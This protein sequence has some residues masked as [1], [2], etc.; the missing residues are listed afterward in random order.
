MSNIKA[1]FPLFKKNKNLVYLDN[2]ATTQ[3]PYAMLDALTQYY[4][5][6]NSNVGRGVYELAQLSENAYDTSKKLVADFIGCS[7]TNLVYTNGCTESLNLAGYISQQKFNKTK[8]YIVLPISEHHANVLIWQEIALKN[9]LELYWI[10][11]PELILDP[12]KINSQILNN[13][14]IMT[15]AHVSNVT[16]E[17]Y[18][19]EIWCK[20]AKDFGA[21]S[22]IDGAQA[23]TSLKINI[24]NI[25]CDFYAFSAHKIYGPMGLGV[26][27]IK[28]KYISANPYKL[29]G[30]IIEDV[31]KS[32]YTLL[33]EINKFEAGTPNVANAYAFGK[34]IEFLTENNWEKLLEKTHE[35]GVYLESELVKI[36]INPLSVSNKF[37]KTHISSFRIPGIHAHDVGT[38]LAKKNIAVRV[39]KHCTYPLHAHLKV[40]SSVRASIGIYN[41]KED[42]DVLIN[43]IKE[44][45]NYFNK[46]IK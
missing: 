15:V 14:A 7:S 1:E 6:F 27:Y 38:Y 43:A 9:N 40:N 42:V 31:E 22:I 41:N 45:I 35:I 10:E 28:D 18:P 19:V 5:E 12:Y 4:I 23:V 46:D 3:K 26:L 17:V 8:K 32:S 33:D 34:T 21:I 39:G 36:G 24:K 13:T 30:G 16:G 25:N 44:C 29:G 2:A 37:D 11:D 20:V